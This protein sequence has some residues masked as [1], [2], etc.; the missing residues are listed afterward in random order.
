VCLSERPRPV[1][2]RASQ[3]TRHRH[4]NPAAIVLSRQLPLFCAELQSLAQPSGSADMF[5]LYEVTGRLTEM[6]DEM[7]P[8]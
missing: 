7:C 1:T 2:H 5:S 3:L 4:F 6:W 8:G